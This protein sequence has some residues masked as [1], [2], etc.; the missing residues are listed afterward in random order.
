MREESSKRSVG[1]G[2]VGAGSMADLHVRA[3]SKIRAVN[4]VAVCSR[5]VETVE[6]RKKEWGIRRGYADFNELVRDPDV[7][8]VDIVA[9]NSLHARIAI[10]ALSAGKPVF[11]EKPPA[12][13]AEETQEMNRA[14]SA[15]GKSLMFGFLFRFSEKMRLVRELVGSGRLGDILYV[16]AGVLRRCGSPGGWFTSRHMAGGGPL[17]DVGVHL[18]DLAAF[19]MGEPRPLSVYG[20]TFTGIGGRESVLNAPRGWKSSMKAGFAY[21]VEDMAAGFVNFSNGACLSIEASNSSHIKDDMMYLE[22]QGT[23]GGI[24]VEPVLE[25]HT[26]L[27]HRLVDSRLRVNCDTFDYQGSIDAEMSHFVDCVAGGAR[28]E[29]GAESGLAVMKIIDALYSSAESGVAVAL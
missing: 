3:F 16:K 17:M 5:Q 24:T 12:L 22:L 4:L 25:L 8:A 11:C 14:A 21:D 2:L 23:R 6:K 19:L 1:I 7:D 28:C 15:S 9:P 10:A 20:K 27:E 18:I 26:E 13:N 29:S